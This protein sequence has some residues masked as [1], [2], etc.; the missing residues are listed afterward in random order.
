MVLES[1]NSKSRE[2]ASAWLLVSSSVL[3]QMMAVNFAKARGRHRRES[4]RQGESSLPWK[5]AGL[6]LVTNHL[7]KAPLTLPQ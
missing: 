5:G 6:L 1:G 3:L 7:S 2:P 4:R